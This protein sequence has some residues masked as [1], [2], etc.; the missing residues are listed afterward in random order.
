M[1]TLIDKKI[2]SFVIND[3]SVRVRNYAITR[4]TNVD[5]PLPSINGS[6]PELAEKLTKLIGNNKYFIRDYLTDEDWAYIVYLS[7]F[8]IDDESILLKS[9]PLFKATHSI[10]RG[11]LNL[12]KQDGWCTHVITGLFISNICIAE[13]TFPLTIPDIEEESK[14]IFQKQLPQLFG[15]LN[16]DDLLLYR[17]GTLIHDLGVIDGVERHDYKGIK[18]VRPALAELG[19][20][21]DWLL[22]INSG[23]SIEELTFALELF[24]GQHAFLSKVYSEYGLHLIRTVL[25]KEFSR[26]GIKTKFLPGWLSEK[27]LLSLALFIIGDIGS[28]RDELLNAQCLKKIIDSEKLL[29]ELLNE[30]DNIREDYEKY[31]LNR[32]KDFLEIDNEKVIRNLVAAI[33]SQT[34][35]FL[36]DLGRIQKLDYFLTYIK[37]IPEKSDRVKFISRLLNFLNN[38]PAWKRSNHQQLN[39]ATNISMNLIHSIYSKENN[40][41]EGDLT[42]HITFSVDDEIIIAKVN[43]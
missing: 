42:K 19:I 2:K 37:Q 27:S 24:V 14:L 18:Y 1:K 16:A 6:F 35:R 5:C 13:K 12:Y 11:G 20:D 10:K 38:N 36:Y 21:A 3:F 31:G 26:S 17:I 41:W 40:K 30:P 9:F 28:V 32:L 4:E 7:Y 33:E 23:W 8:T 34:Q 15:E 29:K 39:F 22:K 25:S 43:E